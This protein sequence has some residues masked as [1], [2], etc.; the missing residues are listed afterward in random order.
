MRYWLTGSWPFEFMK[1]QTNIVGFGTEHY[2]IHSYSCL[3][4]KHQRAIC[5]KK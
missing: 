3:Y 5:Y 1:S 2:H 4:N